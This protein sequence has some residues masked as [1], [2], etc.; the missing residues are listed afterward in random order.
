MSDSV[1]EFMYVH[2][3]EADEKRDSVRNVTYKSFCI[4]ADYQCCIEMRK[5]LL[6]TDS[7]FQCGGSILDLIIWRL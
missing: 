2:N 7:P 6:I 3:D 1:V 5:H 4:T